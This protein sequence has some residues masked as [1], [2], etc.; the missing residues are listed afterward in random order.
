MELAEIKQEINKQISDKE[1]FA[2]LL[3]TTFKGI[4]AGLAK[5]AMMDGMMRGFAFEDFLKKNI[6]AIPFGEGTKKTYS[7]VTSIDYARKIGMRSG[8]VGK[9]APQYTM[10]DEGKTIESCSVTVQRLVE[11]HVGDYTATVFFKEYSTGR[12]LW[13]TK[14]RTMIAKVAEMHAL[15]MACPEELAQAY[16]EEE[17]QSEIQRPVEAIDLTPHKAKLEAV[18]NAE[19]LKTVWANLPI[20]AKEA[21][22]DLKNELK[23]KFETDLTIEKTDENA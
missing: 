2:S 6:Y 16:A 19:E 9:S 22:K 5:R 18:K 3:A 17:V 20:K 12:N 13:T 8:V 7:L 21:L 10:V 15:R 23:A 1:T 11:G 14:P 4:D